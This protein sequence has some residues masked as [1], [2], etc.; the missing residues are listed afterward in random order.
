M[1]GGLCIN[2]HRIDLIHKEEYMTIYL[3]ETGDQIPASE[4][5]EDVYRMEFL[6]YVDKEGGHHEK[7]DFPKDSYDYQVYRA[8]KL[9]EEESKIRKNRTLSNKYIPRSEDSLKVLVK[10]FIAGNEVEDNEKILLSG[11]YSD[12]KA[13]K[14]SVGD[15][16]NYAGQTYECHVEHDNAVYPDIN[17]D[18]PQTWANFWRPLHGKSVST[19]RPWVKPQYG[20][21]DM[22]HIGEYTD[23]YHIGE[24][25][26]Y[27]DRKTYL[28][29]SDTVYSPEEYAQAWEMVNEL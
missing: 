26:V 14:Y 15:I 24:Y 20:T 23:M 3:S 27:T 25:M 12:W 18:N 6:Y 1:Q 13:G 2:R 5:T 11:L 21:T 22:Y 9:P 4:I 8:I 28:C 17:P 7:N 10:A 16:C 19:A 29:K